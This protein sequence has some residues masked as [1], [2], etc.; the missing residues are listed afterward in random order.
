M[1]ILAAID[2]VTRLEGHLKVEIKINKVNGTQQVVDAHATG[3]LFRGF[4]DLLIGRDPRDA[5]HITERIC[6]VCPVAHGLASVRAQDNAYGVASIPTNARLMRNLVHGANFVDSHITH[7]YLLSALDFI[8]G[9][10]MPPWQPN[11]KGDRRLT[12]AQN[13]ALVG[14]YLTAI[15]MRRK[16]Q[17]M[18]ATFGGRVPHP[19]AY[20]AGGFTAN[21]RPE[22]IAAATAYLAEI[23][24][25]IQNTY[26]PDAELLATAYKD[27][28]SIGRGNGNL[29]SY[30]VFDTNDAGTTQLLSSGF[31]ANGSKTPAAF[32]AAAITEDVTFS[33]FDNS[34]NG[35]SP[36]ASQT[37]PQNPKAGA[38]SWLKA[39]RYQG[40]AC[41][42]GPLA[43]MWMSGFYRNGVSVMD[44][45]LARAH[46]AL[47][48]AQAM[49][50]WV[51]QLNSTGAVYNKPTVPAS[52]TGVG[53]TEA[54]RGALGH[55]MQITAGVLSRYQV[56]SPTT[57]A[58][59]PRDSKGQLGPCE[60]AL[61]GTPVQ[62]A[63]EPIEVLRVIHSFDPCLDCAAHII[64][65]N[66][67]VQVIKT[68]TI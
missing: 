38:Y 2:P 32:N 20:I 55:S 44:R 24:P 12:K 42:V 3:A 13:D 41:E 62:N 48:V 36:S 5:A 7:F 40:K 45:H 56:I 53:L 46:E 25:F 21:P 14:H 31:A 57:W 28:L 8:E 16:G 63:D 30:G 64:K 6:G 35:Q 67:D 65:P 4:E 15:A 29:L 52:G 18:G 17:E 27:Y 10:G 66:G 54:P 58:L 50:T 23:I 61:L 60:E 47:R 26:I 68:G 51:S 22:R 19:P 33:W 43:R 59:S 11:W 37:T 39:P 34:A 9:P 1:E 49:Q